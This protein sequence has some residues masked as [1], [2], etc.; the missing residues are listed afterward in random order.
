MDQLVVVHHELTIRSILSYARSSIR[1]GRGIYAAQRPQR[2]A[3]AA[4]GPGR[5]GR[6]AAATLYLTWDKIRA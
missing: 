4:V 5:R 6:H 3:I 2:P 1:A